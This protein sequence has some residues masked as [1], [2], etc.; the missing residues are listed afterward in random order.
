M[1]GTQSKDR[2]ASDRCKRGFTLVEVGV[3]LVILAAAMVLVAQIGYWSIRHRARTSARLL[4]AEL[5][6][7]VLARARSIPWDALTKEWAESQHISQEVAEQL[8]DGT[9]NVQVEQLEAQ[10]FTKRVTVEIRWML[11]DEA[12]SHAVHL[13]GLLS[14][15]AVSAQ[16]INR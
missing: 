4:A 10:P 1:T 2:K 11:V 14:R 12:D 3:A 7:N 8:T 9:L 6:T 15:R 16:Q 5:A 13:V